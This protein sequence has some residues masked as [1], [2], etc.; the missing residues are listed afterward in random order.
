[1]QAVLLEMNLDCELI[2]VD[3]GSTD[4]SILVMRTADVLPR[5]RVRCVQ[6][7]RNA[8]HMSALRV[9]MSNAQGRLIATMD[10]DLQDPPELLPRMVQLLD[11]E[12]LDVVQAERTSRQSDSWFKRS[13]AKLFY[14]VM[15]SAAGLPDLR[16]V[17]DFRVMKRAVVTELLGLSERQLV[18][19]LLLPA[20]GFKIAHVGY[21]RPE[22]ESG[23]S[24]YPLSRMIRLAIDSLT[25][26]SVRPLRAMSML[27]GIMSICFFICSLLSVVAW[28]LGATVPG[29]TSLVFLLLMS[30]AL[31][32]G[33]VGLVGEYVGNT[34]EQVR[35]RPQ[36]RGFEVDLSQ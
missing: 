35:A 6:L 9:G 12:Q 29:W 4:D 15:A 28:A 26:F 19:R 21:D 20:L 16:N 10:A 32:L 30:N 18:Y 31:L 23:E 13:S 2:F 33:A 7:T 8:G 27:G 22:R 17:A 34:F 24:K 25:S 14:R 1:M 11:S 36:P 5:I 3:D